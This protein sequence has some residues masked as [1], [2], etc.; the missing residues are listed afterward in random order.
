MLENRYPTE[1]TEEV[2]NDLYVNLRD[3]IMWFAR[4]KR[5]PE[6]DTEDVF[7]DTMLKVW[8][9]RA[10]FAE[11]GTGNSPATFV[12]LKLR[13][14]IQEWFNVT[15]TGKTQGNRSVPEDRKLQMGI[16]RMSYDTMFADSFDSDTG[17]DSSY[18]MEDMHSRAEL[19]TE[20]YGLVDVP[21]HLTT[22]DTFKLMDKLPPELLAY[23]TC[24]AMVCNGTQAYS[25]RELVPTMKE[26]GLPVRSRDEK[27]SEPTVYA[28]EHRLKT[29]IKSLDK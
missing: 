26:F 19:T 22:M 10:R 11:L 21:D 14:A 16:R 29:F 13:S 5:V 7:H 18:N 2:F 15:N 8:E 6:F 27:S 28:Y 23:V 20:F 1:I 12:Y 4:N 17:D 24:K 25:E 3:D 9:D